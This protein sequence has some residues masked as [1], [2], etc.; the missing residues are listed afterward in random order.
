MLLCVQEI[1]VRGG[2]QESQGRQ[3][4]ESQQDLGRDL[5]HPVEQ[6]LLCTFR[7]PESK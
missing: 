6:L 3:I 1:R 7:T 5:Q 4:V 2:Y